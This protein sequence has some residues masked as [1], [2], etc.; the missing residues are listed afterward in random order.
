MRPNRRSG[1]TSRR[2]PS[3]RP[4]RRPIPLRTGRT[5]R[6][7]RLRNRRPWPSPKPRRPDGPGGNHRAA[8]RSARRRSRTGFAVPAEPAPEATAAPPGE[9]SAPEEPAFIE[10]WRPQRSGR[11]AGR[12]GGQDRQG[13]QERQAQDKPADRPRPRRGKPP[14]SDAGD[15]GQKHRQRRPRHADKGGEPRDGGKERPPRVREER[16]KPVDPN[17]PFAALAALKARLESRDTES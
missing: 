12:R 14:G 4:N 16:Q 13:Q 11:P 17:S 8:G 10:I 5:S 1:T 3:N 6:H 7:R 2:R 9:E 15:N